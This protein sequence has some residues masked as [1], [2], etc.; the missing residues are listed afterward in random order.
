MSENILDDRLDLRISSADK[1]QL[2][3]KCSELQTSYPSLMREIIV[4]LNEGRLRIITTKT[5]KTKSKLYV[6]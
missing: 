1:S 3:L 4:A 6:N 2:L 5:H